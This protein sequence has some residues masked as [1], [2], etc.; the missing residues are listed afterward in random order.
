MG[1][2][3]VDGNAVGGAN[4]DGFRQIVFDLSA[5]VVLEQLRVGP[6]EIGPVEQIPGHRY[7]AAQP[8]EQKEG[9]GKLVAHFGDDVLPGRHGNHVPGVATEAVHPSSAPGEK[10]IGHVRPHVLV[11]EVE[12]R[13]V[14]PDHT[15]GAGIF[16][17]AVLLAGQPLGMG[18]VKAGRPAGVVDGHVDDHLAPTGM[19]RIHQLDKLL[20]WRGGRIEHGQ[21]RIHC[22]ETQG[23]IRAAVAPHAGIG[24]WGRMDG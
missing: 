5:V 10:Y 17:L 15:P 23:R 19:D 7:F 2:G 3:K 21:S 1:F 20:Q 14:G 24:G 6:V 4:I 22:G 12:R 8:F 9:V 16:D 11:A 18:F 13:Q